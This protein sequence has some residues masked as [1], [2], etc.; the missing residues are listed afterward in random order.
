MRNLML[1]LAYDGACFHGWQVQH[2]AVTVQQVFQDAV[3]RVLGE[4]PD[5]K[6][7]SRTDSGVHAAA[8]CVSTERSR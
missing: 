2:N 5:C 3:A 7:C 6:G 4:R 1:T 8:F